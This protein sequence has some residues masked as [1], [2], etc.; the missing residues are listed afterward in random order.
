MAVICATC[1]YVTFDWRTA[2][3]VLNLKQVL[4]L[5]LFKLLFLHI[6]VKF[7]KSNVC[8]VHVVNAKSPNGK[9][10]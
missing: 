2:V 4:V 6:T 1:T 10:F 7:N 9:S 8:R 5:L 3:V